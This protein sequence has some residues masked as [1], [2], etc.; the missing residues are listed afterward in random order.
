MMTEAEYQAKLDEFAALPEGWHEGNSAA[1][2]PESIAVAR[3]F[4]P[5]NC[6]VLFTPFPT[7]DGGVPMRAQTFWLWK[8]AERLYGRRHIPVI[9]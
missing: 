4:G 8:E 2:T 7:F 1:I 6:P 9:A 5:A 3:Q